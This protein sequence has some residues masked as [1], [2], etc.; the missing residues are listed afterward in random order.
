MSVPRSPLALSLLGLAAL[1]CVRSG[2]QVR[3][4]A[5]TTAVLPSAAVNSAGSAAVLPALPLDASLPTMTLAASA[6]PSA[7]VGAAPAAAA[8]VAA[9]ALDGAA[10]VAPAPGL[11]KARTPQTAPERGVRAKAARVIQRAW[12]TLLPREIPEAELIEGARARF[13][14]EGIPVASIRYAPAAFSFDARSPEH[15]IVS[16]RDVPA[17]RAYA[18]R[19]P[20]RINGVRVSLDSAQAAEARQQTMTEF[21]RADFERRGAPAAEIR[22][23]DG[24]YSGGAWTPAHFTV[25]FADADAA[26]AWRERLPRK[27]SG[28]R[29]VLDPAQDEAA[30]SR[31]F[32]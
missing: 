25:S 24:S 11:A 31:D 30:Q 14:A 27:L 4:L 28:V 6:A 32:R 5:E 13:E 23:T 19:L 9:P 18:G 29:V 10:P 16:F 20:R 12:A 1:P 7:F 26:R 17:S 3:P 15:L 2:A 22:Y 8:P 21:A